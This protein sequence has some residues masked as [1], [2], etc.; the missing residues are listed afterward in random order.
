MNSRIR[1]SCCALGNVGAS[2]VMQV[3]LMKHL[4]SMALWVWQGSPC[5]QLRDGGCERLDVNPLHKLRMY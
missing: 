1:Q 2:A 3:L 4:L 5:S